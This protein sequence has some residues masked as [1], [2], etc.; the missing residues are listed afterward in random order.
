[1]AVSGSTDFSMDARQIVTAAF[2]EAKIIA[3]GETPTSDEMDDGLLRLNLMLKTWGSREHLWIVTEGEQALTEGMAAYPIADAR[4]MISVRRRTSNI[5][6][7]MN[8]LARQEYY[9][10]PTKN[11]KATPVS[12]FFDPQRTTRTLFVWPT[13]SARVAANTTL[14]FT[15]MRVIDDID[16]LDDDPDLPQEWLEALV[17]SLAAKLA[18]AYGSDTFAVL[19]AEAE[20]L[21]SALSAQDQEST[22]LYLQPG[23]RQ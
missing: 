11:A 20:Q 18:L 10:L 4:R 15:Y 2:R 17:Y 9:D 23:R 8:E 14:Q 16:A 3:A 6:V 21:V 1:M 22:S 7:P 19:K 5:D 13:A 12:W